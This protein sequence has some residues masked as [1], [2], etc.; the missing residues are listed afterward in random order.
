MPQWIEGEVQLAVIPVT[1]SPSPSGDLGAVPSG[2][3]FIPLPWIYPKC[4]QKKPQVGRV[5][6][7]SRWKYAKEA[8]L[9][10]RALGQQLS[11]HL[12]GTSPSVLQGDLLGSPLVLFSSHSGLLPKAS[13][14]ACLWF[15]SL[16]LLVPPPFFTYLLFILQILSYRSPHRKDL[17]N[18]NSL[19]MQAQSTLYFSFILMSVTFSFI[20]LLSLFR[21][22]P[23]WQHKHT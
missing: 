18:Q 23:Q 11:K 17:T 1:G 20:C 3:D 7:F 2:Q 10:L 21:M 14:P 19:L 4:Y 6:F 9:Q 5:G 22:L 8:Y 12:E 15:L 16:K 13:G